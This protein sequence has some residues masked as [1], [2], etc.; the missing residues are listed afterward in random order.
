[1]PKKITKIKDKKP[2]AKKGKKIKK[3]QQI[4]KN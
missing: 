3:I 2:I 1:M 4:S